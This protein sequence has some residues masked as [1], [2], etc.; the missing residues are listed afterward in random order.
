MTFRVNFYAEQALL[1]FVKKYL[2]N[3]FF[4]NDEIVE[5]GAMCSNAC[6]AAI[7]TIVNSMFRHDGGFRYYENLK[8]VS[9]I[10]TPVDFGNV[11]VNSGIQPW[12]NIARLLRVRNWLVHYKIS[13]IGLINSEGEWISDSLIKYP[14][15]DPETDLSRE[16]V[17]KFY[18]S[19][20]QILRELAVGIQVDSFLYDFLETEQYEAFLVGQV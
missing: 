19:G 12:Q 13:D 6:S 1:S 16:S 7:E 4:D 8:L 11:E 5:N 2:N 20:R 10:E 14:R 18:H 3:T 17:E 15:I 9:R